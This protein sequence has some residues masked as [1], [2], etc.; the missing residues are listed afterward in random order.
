M[1]I[2][3]IA[4]L[5]ITAAWSEPA[6]QKFAPAGQ[7]ISCQLPPGKVNERDVNGTKQWMLIVP[8]KYGFQIAY[9]PM[10]G[11]ASSA[12]P[13]MAGIIQSAKV[14]ETGRKKIVHQGVS[15][16]EVNGTMLPNGVKLYV[17]LRVFPMA[18]KTF[19][20]SG[21]VT[22]QKDKALVDRFFKSVSFSK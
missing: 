20:L 11:P 17:W 19:S 15:G 22:S 4:L 3:L 12:E 16:L 1:R 9:A 10:G 13:F 14:T 8:G 6:W 2:F 21:M 7:G 5:L 18:K